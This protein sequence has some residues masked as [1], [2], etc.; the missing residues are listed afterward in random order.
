MPGKQM[1]I[2]ADLSVGLID[3]TEAR[4]RR[5]ELQKES[6]FFGAMDDASKFE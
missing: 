3:E 5:D 4:E 2:D 1:V 6:D